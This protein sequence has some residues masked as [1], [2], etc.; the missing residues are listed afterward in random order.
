MTPCA[1]MHR[2]KASGS[3]NADL[4]AEDDVLADDDATFATPGVPALLPSQ[5]ASAMSPASPGRPCRR[6][7]SGAAMPSRNTSPRRQP[8]SCHATAFL[9]LGPHL[10]RMPLAVC[11][12]VTTEIEK[13]RPWESRVGSG[14]FDTP[15]ER[16]HRA[17]FRPTVSICCTRAGGQLPAV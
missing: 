12:A 3:Y 1:R 7:R 4:L 11:Y 10:R 15:W 16:M 6:G 8:P 13:G 5:A 2:G 9:G 14:Q 17:N